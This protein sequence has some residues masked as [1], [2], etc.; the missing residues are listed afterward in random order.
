MDKEKNKELKKKLKE[1]QNL[2]ILNAKD[3]HFAEKTIKEM[4]SLKGQIDVEPAHFVVDEKEVIDTLEGETFNIYVTNTGVHFHTKGGYDI[5]ID[6]KYHAAC[7][8]LTNYVV[9]KDEYKDLDGEMKKA[10]DLA[11]SAVTYILTAPLWVFHSQEDTFELATKIVE[12][13]NK[14]TQQ[15]EEEKEE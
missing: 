14:Q 4:L 7:E 9:H 8:L 5:F 1:K 11:L 2:L 3:A 6:A 12:L 10:Y 15:A 13:L